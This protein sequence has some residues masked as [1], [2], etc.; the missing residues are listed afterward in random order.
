MKLSTDKLGVPTLRSGKYEYHEA[1]A[2]LLVEKIQ[3]PSTVTFLRVFLNFIF[4]SACIFFFSRAW[5]RWM[6]TNTMEVL[7]QWKL[8]TPQKT[9]KTKNDQT[10][11]QIQRK[12]KQLQKLQ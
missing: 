4:S 5:S 8:T 3:S 6:L 12:T 10:I 7:S 2:L 1:R 11:K 9:L